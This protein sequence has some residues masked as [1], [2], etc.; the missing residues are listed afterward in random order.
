MPPKIPLAR[1][2][3]ARKLMSMMATLKASA[4]PSMVPRAMA[5][6]RFSFLCSSRGRH[7]DDAGGGGDFGLGDEHLGDEDG[8]GRG[9]DDGGEEVG[10]VDAVCD[11][12]GHDSAGDVS[13]AGG[14]DGHELGVGES[15]E[16]GADGERGF[17][18]AHED[19][20]G[21]VGGFGSGDAHGLLH[22]PGEGADDELHETDVVEDG[23]ER[24]DEDDGGK[25]FEGE[26]GQGGVGAA[27][28]AED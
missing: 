6:M 26:D 24:R 18:L 17:G 15:V 11:V 22:D 28:V 25:D 20:G 1:L 8:A 13:H 21:D 12:G 14:H 27:E 9:H 2:T 19:T 5:P 4:P 7:L 16:E 10:G 3:R 23:E